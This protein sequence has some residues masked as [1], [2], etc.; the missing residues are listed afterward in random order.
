MNA[1]QVPNSYRS[2]PFWSWNEKLEPEETRRQVRLMHDAGI[3]GF[4]MHAR[5]GLQTEYMGEEWF[6]NVTAAVDEAK[7]LGMYAWAYDENGWP[8]GFGSGMVN[9]KGVAY[10][11]KYLRLGAK[12]E[13]ESR[14][15]CQYGEQYF[16]YD[17]NQ[18][19][20]DL[21]DPMVTE[22]FIRVVYEPYYA[23]YGNEIAG[24]FTDEPQLSR[25]GIPWSFVL[26]KEYRAKYGRELLQELPG[27][28]LQVEDYQNIRIR[29]WKLITDL[30]SQNFCKKVYDWC[31]SRGL[32]FTG[33]LVSEETYGEQIT[34][35]GS[36]MPHYEYFSIP[37]MD[38]LGRNVIYD[39]TSYQLGSAAQQLGKKQVLSETFALCGHNVSFDEMRLIYSHQ[40]IHG[41][42]LLCQH[43]EGYSLRGIRKRDYPP[44]M[45]YQQPWWQEYR[46]FC[47]AMSRTGMLLAEGKS[48]C[49][50]LL[51]DPLTTAWALYDEGENPGLEE[52]Y[53]K[54]KKLVNDLDSMHIL[55]HLGDETLMERH[56][57]VNGAALTIGGMTYTTVIL[58]EHTA[59]LPATKK[60]LDEYKANGGRILTPEEVMADSSV[61]DAP[62]ILYTARDYPEE[63]VYYF[64]NHTDKTVEARFGVGSYLMDAATGEK[65]PFT[66][67][68]TFA[69]YETLLLIDDGTAPSAVAEVKPE[70]LDLSGS[71][72]LA[73]VTENV[74]TL[75]FCDYWF[76]G[77]LQE[78]DGYVLNIQTRAL[79]LERPVSIRQAYHV[80][81]EYAPEA[82][83]LVCETPEIFK[84]ITVNGRA[85]DRTD[86]GWFRDKAFRKL[87]IGGLLQTGENEIVFETDFV[88]PDSVYDCLRKSRIFESEK[89]KLTFTMEI[90]PVY[91]V[92]N[93]GVKAGGP[94][95]QLSRNA[96]RVPGRFAITQ[97]PT[98]ITLQ[99]IEQQ[100][101]ACFAGTIT[102]EKEFDL[103]EGRCAVSMH[104]KGVNAVVVEAN[105]ERAG[106]VLYN[107]DVVI[108]RNLK[109]GRNTIRLTLVNNLRNMLGPHHLEEGE[110]YGVAPGSF[111]QEESV[112]GSWGAGAWNGD[113]CLVETSVEN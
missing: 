75:D 25:D 43:L 77:A 40:M 34:R 15:I 4:F 2:I 71:W 61:V 88:Q 104:R 67:V 51:F 66:G 91:L 47:D 109:P 84:S 80:T 6:E 103:A 19:Y 48:R 12:P 42:N 8:S 79:N 58:P 9:G 93:F 113:Y 52:F 94:A 10:Q 78:Q 108:P 85:V 98:E 76:D 22:E 102:V 72:K 24:F 69:P 63:Q 96:V 23:R 106:A 20:V 86:C 35:N 36:C 111:F 31:E 39:L 16:Y 3:G 33:H 38:C 54:F 105:G 68:Y 57:S 49:N 50:T 73:A 41:V 29:F 55:F 89:N 37:G 32:K 95:E 70:A 44:A 45:Y 90:E 7:K 62:E 74:L 60:L 17:V 53:Q 83:W 28:F 110:S 65:L 26:E 99:N 18:F 87:N 11:Q 92:G 27:L 13:D 81:A 82:A 107:G 1:K 46:A 59:M 30:F 5:G 112:Y 14:I 56:G 101:F 97:L 100:G 21:L 64:L